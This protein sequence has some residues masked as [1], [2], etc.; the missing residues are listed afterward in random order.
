MV[1]ASRGP[2]LAVAGGVEAELSGNVF[3]GVSSPLVFEGRATTQAEVIVPTAD[4]GPQGKAWPDLDAATDS[5]AAALA[6][7]PDLGRR[8]REAASA[9]SQGSDAAFDELSLLADE[10]RR[11]CEICR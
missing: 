5:L 2:A 9:A 7:N 3:A 4:P 6:Q 11:S 10:L 8:M 1:A